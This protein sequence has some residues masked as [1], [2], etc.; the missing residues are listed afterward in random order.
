MFLSMLQIRQNGAGQDGLGIALA[1][2][3]TMK[4]LIPASSTVHSAAEDKNQQDDNDKKCCVIHIGSLQWQVSLINQGQVLLATESILDSTHNV[5]DF[6]S[7]LIGF[8]VCLQFGVAGNLA[9]SFFD[10]AFRVLD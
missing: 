5:L 1:R 10:H 4:D 3:P 9:S 6:A 8:A 2:P 7:S